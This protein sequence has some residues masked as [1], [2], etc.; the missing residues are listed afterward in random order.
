MRTNEASRE[1]PVLLSGT[2]AALI[3]A[4][5]LDVVLKLLAPLLQRFGPQMGVP[6]A[7]EIW[8]LDDLPKLQVQQKYSLNY[9]C[10][11][12]LCTLLTLLFTLYNAN[13]AE[14]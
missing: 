12:A 4:S 1:I 5:Y 13:K 14:L 7:R 10:K 2:S 8:S 11:E 9:L 3:W 6:F